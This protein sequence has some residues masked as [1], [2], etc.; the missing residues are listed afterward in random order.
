MKQGDMEE[1]NDIARKIKEN[2]TPSS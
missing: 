1:I 2:L